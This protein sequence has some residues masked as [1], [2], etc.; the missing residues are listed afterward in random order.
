MNALDEP[1]LSNVATNFKLP[2]LKGLPVLS[3]QLEWGTNTG[4][5]V[6]GVYASL[7]L[8]PDALNLAGGRGGASRIADR[9]KKL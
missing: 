9:L 8:G 6:M 7:R 3:E 1:L 4:I 2:I 5:Y